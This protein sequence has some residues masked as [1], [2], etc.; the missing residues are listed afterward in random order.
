MNS[1]SVLDQVGW[2]GG[3][4]WTGV[5]VNPLRCPNT[6]SR[7]SLS[8]VKVLHCWTQWEIWPAW[9]VETRNRKKASSDGKNDWYS[10]TSIDWSLLIMLVSI[11]LVEIDSSSLCE[12]S[13]CCTCSLHNCSVGCATDKALNRSLP[14]ACRES[15]PQISGFTL[16]TK[17][18]S[19]LI[20]RRH[21]SSFS[22]SFSSL[23]LCSQHLLAMW[24]SFSAT[25]SSVRS[26]SSSNWAISSS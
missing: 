8:E 9:N 17:I 24:A 19:Q 15:L 5:S 4:T 21:F 23:S 14:F 12:C 18:L 1:S 13:N 25:A 3:I 6:V 16:G 26:V 7:I 10:L 11:S 2:G 22:F 20:G